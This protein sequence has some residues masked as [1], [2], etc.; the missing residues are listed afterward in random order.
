[1]ALERLDAARAR[2]T[3]PDG[4]VIGMNDMT[5]DAATRREAMYNRGPTT[6]FASKTDPRFA[7]TMFVPPRVGPATTILV[8][9]HG[10]GRAMIDMRNAFGEF[11]RY[12]DC[13]VLAPLF[14]VGPL[15]DGNSDG[16]K[17][18]REG[19]IRY[20]RV[21][22]GMIDEVA[23]RYG[24]NAEKFFL[25]GYSGG[26]HFAHRFFYLH[27]ERLKAVS[28]GAPGSVTL[29]DEDHDYW[30]GCR[31]LEALFGKRLD[32][33]AMR[34]V[35]VHQVVGGAD[36]ETWEITHRQGGRNWM[37]GA[38]SAGE[39]RVD[40]STTLNAAFGKL[41]IKTRFDIIPGMAHDNLKAV[42]KVKDF[43]LDVLQGRF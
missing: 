19:D 14:P 33:P 1:M 7:Y 20:D 30:V 28:I 40:R 31:N 12:N 22:L 39:T 15:G 37:E 35:P 4:R 34:K 43:F 6:V 41:G 32:I 23:G 13:L 36:R 10:T 21:L 38:N 16:F 24:V 9:Q 2:K 29:P 5:D 26:G 3:A 27:P 25:Y 18:I 8:A 17:Y 42:G 11:G